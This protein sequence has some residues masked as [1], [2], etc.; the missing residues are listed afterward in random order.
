MPPEFLQKVVE[1]M[2]SLQHM[3]RVHGDSYFLDRCERISYN[4]LPATLTADMWAHQYLQQ[5]RL[6][7][8][9]MQDSSL[10]Q[11]LRFACLNAL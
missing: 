6:T 8:W 7:M 1:Q 5:V 3:F 4:S 10:G 2:Y 11:S 9:S